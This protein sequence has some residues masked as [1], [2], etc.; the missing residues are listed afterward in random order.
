MRAANAAAI[1]TLGTE[2]TTRH[3]FETTVVGNVIEIGVIEIGTVFEDAE[4]HQDR[5]DRHPVE[6]SGTE[7]VTFRSA[8]RPTA[9]Q[10]GVREIMAGLLVPVPPPQILHLPDNRT[11]EVASAAEEARVAGEI[12]IV[13]EDVLSLMSDLTDHSGVDLRKVAGVVLAVT[14]MTGTATDLLT[15]TYVLATTQGKNVSCFPGIHRAIHAILPTATC[16]RRLTD[17]A[18]SQTKLPQPRPPRPSP[19]PSRRSP[20]RLA[21]LPPALRPRAPGL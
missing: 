10:D 15:Q 17:K 2:E 6:I 8:S 9:P 14:A 1:E 4:H 12:G 7:I 11:A 18:P 20:R 13:A 16:A 21:Q 3:H 19:H 5:D